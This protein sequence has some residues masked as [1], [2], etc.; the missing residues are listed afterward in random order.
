MI[1]SSLQ[2][3]IELEC[4]M[5]DGLWP[6]EVD[7][8]ELELALVNVAVNARDAMPE[9]GTITLSARNATVE[10]GEVND[11]L[12]GDFVA[13]TM[14]DTGTGI[15]RELLSRVFEPF[16]TTK[17][18][19]KGTGLG[20]SQVYGFAHQ[21]GGG[22]TIDSKVGHGTDITIYLPRSGGPISPERE[23]SDEPLRRG[24]GTILVVEDNPE[25]ASVS[26]ALLTQLGYRV[27]AAQGA[28]EALILLGNAQFD[29]VFSDIVM[30][31]SMN[32]LALA[33]EIRTRYP[34]LPVLLTSGYSSVA[35]DAEGEF[36]ILRKPY[37]VA[38]LERA[39]RHALHAAGG[40][41]P[42]DPSKS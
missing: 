13:I 16:F 4:E 30:P 34:T 22:I 40:P 39:V 31:G 6:V 12:E 38:G 26:S 7:L 19:G 3:D 29:L 9:G 41:R 14:R 11:H 5:P 37:Q 36:T 28:D 35:R 32:G 33:R 24:D 18:A 23:T 27:T 2:G 10:L 8:S 25:V 42:A 15:P 21:S 17:A 1:G 20:L